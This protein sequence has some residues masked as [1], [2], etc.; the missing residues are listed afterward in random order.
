VQADAERRIVA[1]VETKLRIEPHHSLL[2]IGCGPGN[3]LIPLSFK[4]GRAVGLDHPKVV[5]QAS[6][7][8]TDD[9]VEWVGAEFPDAAISG[10]F[11]RI[12]IYSVVHYLPSWEAVLR[13]ADAAVDLLA[14]HGRLLIGDLPNTDRKRRF[15][16]SDDGRRFDAAWR[17]AMANAPA[18]DPA[19]PRPFDG[20]DAIGGF[21][22][23]SLLDLVARYR[24][25]GHHAYLLPQ[26]GDL[27][28][29]HTREDILIERL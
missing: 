4:A 8:F 14:P 22:D 28:F 11:D 24:A 6:R 15:Q 10:P 26:L 18:S 3:L 29:G 19:A 5:A 27:P 21:D 16:N 9:S 23:R 20:L 2:E 7:R 13:F 25:R 1:D 17:A 12:L